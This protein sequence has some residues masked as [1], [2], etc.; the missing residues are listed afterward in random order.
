MA[1][2]TWMIHGITDMESVFPGKEFIGNFHTHGLNEYGNHRELCIV[3]AFPGQ[4]AQRLLN[5]MGLRIAKKE[6]VFTEGIRNDIL[7]NEMDVEFISF[8]NDPTLYVILPDENGKLPSDK[9][10]LT[11]YKYQ[12]EYAKLIHDNEDYV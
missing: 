9:D 5:D 2:V 7:A 6:T 3:L 11:P 4:V 12:Y 10:C 1:E 8:D